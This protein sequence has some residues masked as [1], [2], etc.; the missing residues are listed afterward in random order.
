MS[1][2]SKFEIYYF[3]QVAVGDR[4]GMKNANCCAGLK[5]GC[6]SSLHIMPKRKYVAGIQNLGKCR[7]GGKSLIKRM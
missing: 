7:A 5:S 6:P 3:G 2:I 1:I 4:V